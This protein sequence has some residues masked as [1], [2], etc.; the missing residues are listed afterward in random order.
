MSETRLS[1]EPKISSAGKDSASGTRDEAQPV[2][3]G[4]GLDVH[5]GTFG[6]WEGRVACES[7][8]KHIHCGIVP[9][10]SRQG[11]ASGHRARSAHIRVVSGSGS[12]AGPCSAGL[13]CG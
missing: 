8:H 2:Q 3:G 9:G 5:E 7:R 4:S 1:T 10:P 12:A 6:G 11:S 13:S